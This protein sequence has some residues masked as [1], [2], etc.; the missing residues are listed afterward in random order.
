MNKKTLEKLEE[1]LK[2]E[3]KEIEAQLQ[4]FAT[5]DKKLK[6][7]WDTK[8]PKINEGAGSQILEEGADQVEEYVNLLPV[9]YSLELRLQSINESLEKIKKGNYGK[10]EKCNKE[11]NKERLLIYPAAKLCS[12]C[13]KKGLNKKYP[14]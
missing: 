7:D 3:K 8:Y 5:K 1:K 9:E 11:I 13:E 4:K 6:G 14:R 10:C 12:E 2:K